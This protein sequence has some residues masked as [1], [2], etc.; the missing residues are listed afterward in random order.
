MPTNLGGMLKAIFDAVH[1]GA[2]QIH[3]QNNSLLMLQDFS[4]VPI[5]SVRRDFSPVVHYEFNTTSVCENTS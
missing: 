3:C 2:Q 1:E 4:A 5:L